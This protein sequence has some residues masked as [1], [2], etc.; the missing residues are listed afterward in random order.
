MSFVLFSILPTLVEFALVCGVLAWNY[1]WT[2]VTITLITLVG[3]IAYTIFVT[4][5]RTTFRK[6]MNELDSKANSKAI[7]SLLNYETVKYFGNERFEA[8]RYDESLQRWERAAFA[9]KT[10]LSLLNLGKACS[11]LLEPLVM[12]RA[13][14]GVIAGR[15]TVGDLV[16]VNAFLIQLYVPLNFWVSSIAKFRQSMT[17][18][19]RMFSLMAEHQEAADR[20]SGAVAFGAD[21]PPAGDVVFDNVHFSHESD[22]GI[23]HG[24]N[25]HAPA[26]QTFAVVGPSG[27]VRVRWRGCCFLL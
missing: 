7:D 6:E 9:H 24:V 17:D 11:S 5:W 27:V 20:P 21:A 16:L 22:R 10:S 12:W 19:G 4:E 18:M 2:F 23:L 25:F 3:Y 13:I 26:G 1:D 15:M 14:E 8:D